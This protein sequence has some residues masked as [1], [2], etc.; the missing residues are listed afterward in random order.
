MN[1]RTRET[2]VRAALYRSCGK[3]AASRRVGAPLSMLVQDQPLFAQRRKRNNTRHA[4]T[5]A[6][7]TDALRWASP[8]RNAHRPW[9][10]FTSIRR[11]P[12]EC[13]HNL[14][15]KR[16]VALLAHFPVVIDRQALSP[17][18]RVLSI[19]GCSR[20]LNECMSLVMPA[21]AAKKES[22]TL[23]SRLR[24]R[25]SRRWQHWLSCSIGAVVVFGFGVDAYTKRTLVVIIAQV[26]KTVQQTF[27]LPPA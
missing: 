17:S 9:L 15:H 20:W 19:Q 5:P 24:S 8:S 23:V 11:G 1:T 27:K 10:R 26:L 6:V 2:G 21:V 16:V 3:S 13:L 14:V 25:W 18:R 12:P 22:K 4:C 7:L